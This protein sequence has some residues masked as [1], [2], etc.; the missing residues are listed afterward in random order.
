MVRDVEEVGR[1]EGPGEGGSEGGA[2]GEEGLFLRK[3][4]ER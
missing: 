3:W 4:E 1:Q 2:E